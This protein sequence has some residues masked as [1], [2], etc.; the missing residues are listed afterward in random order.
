M[1]QKLAGRLLDSVNSDEPGLTNIETTVPTFD[2]AG[3]G[4]ELL[5]KG[6]KITVRQEGKPNFGAQTLSV[7]IVQIR[8]P[9]REGIVVKF[10]G[11]VGDENGANGM[12]GKTNNHYDKLILA[13]GI[14]ALVSLGSNALAGTPSGFYA[15]TA[16]SAA[17]ETSQ[18][19][20]R[21]VKSFTDAQLRV[22]PTITKKAGEIVTIQL[23]EN[24]TFSA[25]PFVVR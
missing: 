12:R 10:P 17:R 8:L 24:I 9:G 5:P 21:D 7:K 6:S 16:Q 19:V 1:D 25:K 13:T 3:W 11:S 18:S 15:N 20:S 2:G 14:N 4:W 22:G 23:E